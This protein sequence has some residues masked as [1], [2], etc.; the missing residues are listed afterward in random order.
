L[1][2]DDL[3]VLSDSRKLLSDK[4]R[5]VTLINSETQKDDSDNEYFV[6]DKISTCVRTVDLAPLLGSKWT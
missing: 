4:R 6:E 5:V 3:L 1:D 2:A